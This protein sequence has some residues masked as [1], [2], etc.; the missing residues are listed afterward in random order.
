MLPLRPK[1]SSALLS[2]VLILAS[3]CHKQTSELP[4]DQSE[5]NGAFDIA[6]AM[7]MF[8]GNYDVNKQTSVAS[9]PKGKSRFPAAGE[10]QMTVRMLFSAFSGDTGA[11][12]FVIVTYAVPTSDETFDCHAC[13]PIIGMA[14]FSQKGLKWTIDASNRAVTFSGE[15]GKPPADIQLVQIG[16]NHHAV[17]VIDVGGGQGETTQ[18]LDLLVPWNGTVNLGLQRII[19]DDDKGGCGPSGGG[20]PCY[21]NRRTVT[22]IP[23]DKVEHYDLELKLMGTDLPVSDAHASRRA[24]KV[25]G[26][27]ILKFENGKYIQVSRQGD[28]T[29]VD[30]AVARQEDLK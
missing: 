8:Y 20:L 3:G 7:K 12:R 6:Q 15:W 4:S 28:L 30:D 13:A 14:V 16:P 5:T 17:K 22:F 29:Y 9:L 10:E 18:V 21:A 19:A 24:R 11:Q 1:S 2:A 26:L 27:E 25:N 23:K